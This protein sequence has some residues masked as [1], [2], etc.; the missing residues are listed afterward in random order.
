MAQTP[1]SSCAFVLPY[2]IN[3]YSP[4]QNIP[5]C[6]TKHPDL[7]KKTSKVYPTKEEFTVK[8]IIQIKS[9]EEVNAILDKTPADKLVILNF[10]AAWAE[11][12]TQMN[13]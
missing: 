12:C 9:E 7:E 6:P 8:M 1:L 13:Q 11:P 10:Y 2:Q 4:H 5:F 3:Q